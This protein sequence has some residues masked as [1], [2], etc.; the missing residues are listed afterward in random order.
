MKH[1]AC[2]KLCIWN[3]NATELL[4][5]FIKAERKLCSYGECQMLK[6][7]GNWVEL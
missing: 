3:L 4:N 6:S 2:V 1:S 7:E 5:I